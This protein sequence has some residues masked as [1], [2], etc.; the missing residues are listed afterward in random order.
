VSWLDGTVVRLSAANRAAKL[1]PTEV[2]R[3]E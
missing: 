3:Y 1:H 2:L